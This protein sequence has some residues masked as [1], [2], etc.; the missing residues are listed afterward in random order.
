VPPTLATSDVDTLLARSGEEL[1][2]LLTE[3]MA[4]RSART[5]SALVV[6]EDSLQD[7]QDMGQVVAHI[8]Q[9]REELGDEVP[10]PTR[11]ALTAMAHRLNGWAEPQRAAGFRSAFFLHRG[12]A[13]A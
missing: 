11:Q 10:L 3:V 7:D 1:R 8:H 9:L 12:I 5:R 4:V 13:P 6:F 2:R